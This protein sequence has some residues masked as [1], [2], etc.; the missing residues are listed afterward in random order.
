MVSRRRKGL[1]FVGLGLALLTIQVA[2][3]QADGGALDP[4]FG[5]GGLVSTPT[6]P[7]S[8]PLSAGLFAVA[9]QADGKIV[10][11]GSLVPRNS[12]RRA[13]TVVRYGV[14]GSLDPTFGSGGVVTT[15]FGAEFEGVHGLAIQPDGKIVAA[16]EVDGALAL[17]RYGPD[18]SLDSTFG[19]GPMPGTVVDNAIGGAKAVALQPDGKIVVSAGRCCPAQAAVARFNANGSLDASFGTAGVVPTSGGVELGE[20]LALGPDGKIV[21]AGS[22]PKSSTPGD[23]SLLVLRLNPDGSPDSGFGSG[24]ATTLNIGMWGSAGALALQPDGKILVSGALDSQVLV[25]FQ[26]TGALD[27]TFGDH[28][29][30]RRTSVVPHAVLLQPDGKVVLVGDEVRRYLPDGSVDSSFGVNGRVTTA[31]ASYAGALQADG[32]ILAV[33]GAGT[34]RPGAKTAFAL[35]RYLNQDSHLLSF[36]RARDTGYGGVTSRPFGIVCWNNCRQDSAQFSD[37]SVVT[38]TAHALQ[39][40]VVSWTGACAGSGRVCRVKMRQAAR[41]VHV[42]FSRCLVPRLK[43][44]RAAVARTAIRR[45]HCSVGRTATQASR[46]VA[47]GRVVSQHPAAGTNLPAG[48][49]VSVVVSNGRG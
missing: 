34:V 15:S 7:S 49:K 12:Q 47:K 41:S 42:Q 6:P 23:T 36:T 46:N 30:V 13:F 44:K 26:P 2:S 5:T 14:G 18:G 4:T 3:A 17:A 21:V 11:G 16:G 40:S 22:K 8:L 10:A 33:G 48:S 35:A 32:K 24:E 27:P 1:T 31:I 20:A 38:L 25:R 43:G 9:L 19:T 39:G 37:Q 28:G 45:A 29:I